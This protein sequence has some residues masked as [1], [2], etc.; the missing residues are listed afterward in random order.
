M[1]FVLLVPIFAGQT[2]MG[3]VV[4]EEERRRIVIE[5]HADEDHDILEACLDGFEDE[6]EIVRWRMD[7]SIGAP[8]S[9]TQLRRASAG[10]VSLPALRVDARAVP[11]LSDGV[12]LAEDCQRLES[13]GR[14]THHPGRSNEPP[15]HHRCDRIHRSRR[16]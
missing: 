3:T 2:L 14:G 1:L 15:V 8:N 16:R 9:D 11:D 5:V 6:V 4:V 7:P 10:V 13:D 12:F